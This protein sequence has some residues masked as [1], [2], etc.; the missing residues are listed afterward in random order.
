MYLQHEGCIYYSRSKLV[1]L[2]ED[3]AQF[4]LEDSQDPIKQANK[5]AFETLLGHPAPHDRFNP[6]FIKNVVKIKPRGLP[7][8]INY[9]KNFYQFEDVCASE[10]TADTLTKSIL[11]KIQETFVD[12][13]N[14]LLISL[15][16][17]LYEKDGNVY[18][19]DLT[20]WG[21]NPTH[22]LGVFIN[23]IASDLYGTEKTLFFPFR[24]LSEKDMEFV[25]A[26]N[27][28]ESVAREAGQNGNKEVR[29][30]TL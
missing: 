20:K 16:E 6:E 13:Y 5:I 28:V 29:I 11:E 12:D 7:R 25:V 19:T 14:P 21:Y 30:V 2:Y 27:A 15:D 18:M 24:P 8:F 22:K 3:D 26:L 4:V 9:T 17:G 23:P 1:S 10:I